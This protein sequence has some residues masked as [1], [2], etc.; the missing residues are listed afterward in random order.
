MNLEIT[1]L[2]I[3]CFGFDGDYFAR[4]KSESRLKTLKKF[5][6]QHYSK[7]D[8]F[9]FQ[10]I[11][12]VSILNLILP[13]GFK[14]YTYEHKFNRH[15]FV[16]LACKNEFNF[17]DIQTIANTALDDTKSRPVIYGKLSFNNQPT[18][19]IIGLHLKSG[20]DHT[21]KRMFQCDLIQK[22]ILNLDPNIPLIMGGDFNSHFKIKTKKDKDDLDYFREIFKDTLT[23]AE[24]DKSTYVLPTENA[25]LDH[26]WTK[27]L[28]V[29]N[30]E[31]FDLQTYCDG[32][33]LKN[34]FNEISDHLPVKLSVVL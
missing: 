13:E 16:V 20:F 30:I 15:M 8:V 25:H 12:D 24:H 27:G 5:I 33:V 2:N 10:E 17:T 3:R 18:A 19:H 26:F 23:L 34:Y 4:N 32:N 29:D 1:T 9:I 7:S 31:V 14:F 6:N 11:M 28:N 22:F 21:D